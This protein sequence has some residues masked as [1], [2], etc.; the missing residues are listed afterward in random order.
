MPIGAKGVYITA[1]IKS[2]KS[3]LDWIGLSRV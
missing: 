1:R 3:R 2:W